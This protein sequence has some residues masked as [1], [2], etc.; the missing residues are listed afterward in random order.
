MTR[1]RIII[2]MLCIASLVILQ[3]FFGFRMHLY[4]AQ[5]ELTALA[6]GIHTGYSLIEEASIWNESNITSE[7]FMCWRGLVIS[8]VSKITKQRKRVPKTTQNIPCHSG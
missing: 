4:H 7:L 1:R 2:W 6:R 5:S 8:S 3:F